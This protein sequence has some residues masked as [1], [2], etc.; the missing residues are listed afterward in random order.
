MEALVYDV[1]APQHATCLGRPGP[2]P[3]PYLGPTGPVRT[4]SVLTVDRST[5][6][7]N[8]APHV[9]GI[10]TMDPHVRC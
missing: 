1:A 2:K 4:R 9:S 3:S 8:L 7:I 5:L 6:T 10:D